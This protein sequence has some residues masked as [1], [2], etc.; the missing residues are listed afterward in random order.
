MHCSLVQYPEAINI[1]HLPNKLKAKATKD[2]KNAVAELK[3]INENRYN[4]IAKWS[5][6]VLQYMNNSW[7]NNDYLTNDTMEYMKV[8]DKL[9]ETDFL[10]VYPEF[11]EYWQW[12]I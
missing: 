6:Y 10:S 7:V 8:M 12:V 9:N 11:K 5:N 4:K 3:N 2:I 1:K